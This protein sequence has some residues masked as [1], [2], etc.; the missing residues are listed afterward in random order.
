VRFRP[1]A[2]RLFSREDVMP[3]TV[4]VTYRAPKGDSKVCELYGRTFFDGQ[5]IEIEDTPDNEH[6]IAKLSR[7]RFFEVV[8]A[9]GKKLLSRPKMY[10]GNQPAPEPE[11]L[12][13][14]PEPDPEPDP[15]PELE[16]EPEPEPKRKSAPV[17]RKLIRRLHK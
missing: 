2:G 16:P 10:G 15:I 8:K 9:A 17:A 3:V 12:P 6:A 7:N 1:Q 11:P 5:A 4:S 14:D 13:D